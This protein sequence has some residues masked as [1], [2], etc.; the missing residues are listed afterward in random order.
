MNG[1]NGVMIG[2]ST[3]NLDRFGNVVLSQGNDSIVLPKHASLRTVSN[4]V[5][6]VSR[7]S[8]IIPESVAAKKSVRLL[9]SQQITEIKFLSRDFAKVAYADKSLAFVNAAAGIKLGD[10][11]TLAVNDGQI[12]MKDGD[13]I[14][15]I[16][17]RSAKIM[18]ANGEQILLSRA[19]K[20]ALTKPAAEMLRAIAMSKQGDVM[21]EM[22]G[23][24]SMSKKVKRLELPGGDAISLKYKQAAFCDDSVGFDAENGKQREAC[25]STRQASFCSKDEQGSFASRIRRKI[26]I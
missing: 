11:K 22:G 8:Q 9:K 3:L 4:G 26:A 14:K 25:N 12:E 16:A 21:L 6:S 20:S 10:G 7:S 15:Q 13:N 1:R 19:S 2:S 18:G 5:V 17:A 24:I 23:D